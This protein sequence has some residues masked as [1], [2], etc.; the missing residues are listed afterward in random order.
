[1]IAVEEVMVIGVV[2]QRSNDQRARVSVNPLFDRVQ[3][4]K[5]TTGGFF[6]G[7]KKIAGQCFLVRR[8][9]SVPSCGK[10]CN[11]MTIIGWKF[12]CHSTWLSSIYPSQ[13]E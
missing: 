12:E 1:M 6:R 10:I 11:E 2:A 4:E 13:E 9:D 5:D 8:T 7:K 3:M